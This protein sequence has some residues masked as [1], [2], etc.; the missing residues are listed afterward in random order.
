MNLEIISFSKPNKK[1]VITS[2]KH[3]TPCTAL[4]FEIPI[5][6]L[7]F[8]T[9]LTSF[10]SSQYL[11][12]SV[13]ITSLNLNITSKMSTPSKAFQHHDTKLRVSKKDKIEEKNK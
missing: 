8:Q 9:S 11:E 6:N 7:K 5:W 3:V 1:L 4:D 2:K 10:L 13:F 12:L